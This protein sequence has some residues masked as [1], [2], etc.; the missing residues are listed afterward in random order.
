MDLSRLMRFHAGMAAPYALALLLAPTWLIG[1][2]SP[3]GLGPAGVELAR[4]FGAATVL[5]SAVAWLGAGIEDARARRKL[6]GLLWLYTGLG[7]ALTLRGQLAGS[8]NALGWSNVAV[9]GVLFVAYTKL[10][11][12]PQHAR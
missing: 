10:L 12:N 5:V 9:Y 7:T 11:L 1:L 4:L 2:L 8:W 3:H 6:A